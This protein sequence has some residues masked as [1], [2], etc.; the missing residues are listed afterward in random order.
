MIRGPGQLDKSALTEA[1]RRDLEWLWYAKID[2][3]RAHLLTE[4]R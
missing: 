3:G 2:Q 1:V 4:K